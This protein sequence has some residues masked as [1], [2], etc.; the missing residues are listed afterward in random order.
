MVVSVGKKWLVA[1]FLPL[2][3]AWAGP[4]ALAQTGQGQLANSPPANAAATLRAAG[5]AGA[6][7]T[8]A[9]A[10]APGVATVVVLKGTSETGAAI[11]VAQ[12]RGKVVMV[13]GWSTRCAVCLNVM[14]ELRNNLAGWQGQPFELVSI[15]TDARADELQ[16]WHR[17]RV[18]TQSTQAHWPSLWAGDPGLVT[19]LDLRGQLPAIWV[20]DKT[21]VLRFQ[22]RG[23]MPAEAWDQVAELL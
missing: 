3:L 22:S 10:A 12:W 20:L 1:G 13:Y 7:V 5:A 6:A 2:A 15:N 11:D 4:A 17:L 9:P 19:N 8:A 16:S 21:G 14:A 23:R 18:Q